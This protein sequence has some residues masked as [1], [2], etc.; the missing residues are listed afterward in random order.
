MVLHAGNTFHTY[1][2]QDGST[3]SVLNVSVPGIYWVNALDFCG[4]NYTDSIIINPFDVSI[5]IGPDRIKCNND[6]LQ[7]AG[8]AGF[9]NYV[10]SNNY[11]INTTTGQNVVINPLVDTVYYLIAEKTPGCFAYDTIRIKVNQSSPIYLGEDIGICS[12]D[13]VVLN[14]GTGFDQYQWSNGI[15]TQQT[16]VFSTGAYSIIGTAPNGCRSYDTL[17]VNVWPN[18]VVALDDNPQLCFGSPRNLQAGNY[19]SYRWQDGSTFNS[20]IANDIGIYYVTVTDG[21]QC[22]GSDTVHITTLLQSPEKFLPADTVV[23]KYG[24]LLLQ[25]P[26]TYDQYKWSNN[27]ATSSI[28]VTSPGL[29]WLEVMDAGQ[30]TGRDT[31]I[32]LQKDCLSGFYIPTA[33]TPGNNGL[34]DYFKPIIGGVVEEYQFTIYNRWGQAIFTTKDLNKGWNGTIAGLQQE[35]NVFAWVCS[36]RLTGQPLKKEQGTVVVI[37]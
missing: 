30:C 16:A 28:N 36:Y 14:A 31:I 10:W 8:P 37:K 24:S 34:N 12:G 4:N 7:L 21:H 9:M 26:N 6:T 17:N 18:P 15:S 27:A 11:A 5:N 19:A 32:V 33:F 2:W 13:T 35:T 1:Q 3:D 20:F 23:C 22:I 29:Y 25:S